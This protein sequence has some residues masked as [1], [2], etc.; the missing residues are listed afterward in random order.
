MNYKEFNKEQRRKDRERHKCI[1]YTDM[2]KANEILDKYKRKL[3][4]RKKFKNMAHN[5]DKASKR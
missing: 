1:T 3:E 5:I 4:E 2:D